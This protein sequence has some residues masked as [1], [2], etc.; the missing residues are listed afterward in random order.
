[1]PELG[2]L[3]LVIPITQLSFVVT[4]VIGSIVFKE[5]TDKFKIVGIA[6]AVS[7]VLLMM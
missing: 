1:M 4:S 6:F 2:D 7:A 5:K 3:S